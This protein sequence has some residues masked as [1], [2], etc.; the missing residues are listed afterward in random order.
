MARRDTAYHRHRRRCRSWVV[1]GL[2]ATLTTVFRLGTW[3]FAQRC[4]RLLG[5]IAWHLS[6]RER[7]RALEHLAWAF[8][9][10][11]PRERRRLARECFRHQLTNVTECLYLTVREPEQAGRR[12]TVAGWEHAAAVVAAGRPLLLLTAHLGNWELLAAVVVGRGLRL[13]A[14]V[15]GL[16]D[17][18]LQQTLQGLRRHL[19]SET[20]ERGEPGAARKLLRALRSGGALCLLIDQDTPVDGNWV[21][22]FG[23]PAFTP[24]GAA[25]LALRHRAAV[26]PVFLT[27]CPGGD[28]QATFLPPLDLPPDP[29]AAT[30]LMTRV[31]EEQIRRHPEQWVWFHR[32]WR[33][34]PPRP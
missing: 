7:R 32:R 25:R 11:P 6:R 23:R 14:V 10:Q 27:R 4:G 19:G 22:F 16:D 8:P 33:R 17:P 13:Y 29:T 24:L 31:I 1:G 18:V 28:H 15:R 20:I 9:D 30:A 34:Q 5:T 2:L 21:P 12:V 3:S 26:V